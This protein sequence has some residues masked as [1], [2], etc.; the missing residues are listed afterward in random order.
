MSEKL[1]NEIFLVVMIV[2]I[3]R[4]VITTIVNFISPKLV[5]LVVWLSELEQRK[6]LVNHRNTREVNTK[7]NF[8]V[9]LT[10]L[11]KNLIDR[12]EDLIYLF[13]SIS[14]TLL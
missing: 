3:W 1:S 13:L 10:K 9:V 7:K 6:R 11:S 5:I 4:K 12:K 14:V 2:A 8:L